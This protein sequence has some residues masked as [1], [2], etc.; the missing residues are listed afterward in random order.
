MTSDELIS[1]GVT[2]SILTPVD[3]TFLD[4]DGNIVSV[5]KFVPVIGLSGHRTCEKCGQIMNGRVFDGHTDNF[6]CLRC[7]EKEEE[8]KLSQREIAEALLPDM[9]TVPMTDEDIERFMRG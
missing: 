7:L 1:L 5:E 3:E 2:S 8:K 9:T 4:K 6:V